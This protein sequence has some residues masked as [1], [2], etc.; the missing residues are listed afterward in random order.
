MSEK[1][2]KSVFG[3]LFIFIVGFILALSGCTTYYGQPP[4]SVNYVQPVS[5]Q[6]YVV[7]SAPTFV[8]STNGI[9]V[10]YY[11]ALQTYLYLYN[12]FYYRWFN[13][14]WVYAQVYSGPWFP[15]AIGVSLPFPLRY[16]PPVPVVSYQ[17]YFVWWK[18]NI[19]PWYR[20]HYP[21]WWNIHHPFL[22]HYNSWQNHIRIYRGHI[23]QLYPMRRGRPAV[24]PERGPANR[25]N[26]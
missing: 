15:R 25:Y 2:K 18:A 8:F 17:P 26:R 22:N 21:Q 6:G 3:I 4:Y 20:A 10:Y 24:G 13:G 19:G 16:G 23:Q 12:G 14:G 11:P 7:A 9:N 1:I 5:P